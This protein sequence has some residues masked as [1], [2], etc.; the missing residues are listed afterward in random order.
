MKY[1]LMLPLILAA[2][3]LSAASYE[4]DL[5]EAFPQQTLFQKL[6]VEGELLQIEANESDENLEVSLSGPEVEF[7]LTTLQGE[8]W[9]VPLGTFQLHVLSEM[10]SERRHVLFDLEATSLIPTPGK[11]NFSNGSHKLIGSLY[12]ALMSV[13]GSVHVTLEASSDTALDDA[14]IK[15]DLIKGKQQLHLTMHDTANGNHAFW[16]LQSNLFGKGAL[17]DFLITGLREWSERVQEST[18]ESP[19]EEVLQNVC[20]Q[21]SAFMDLAAPLLEW[22]GIVLA[23]DGESLYQNQPDLYELYLKNDFKVSTVTGEWSA[24]MGSRSHYVAG[25]DLPYKWEQEFVVTNLS[26][27]IEK[28]CG[29]IQVNAIDQLAEYLEMPSLK[30]YGSYFPKYFNQA[31]ATLIMK[32]GEPQEDGTLLLAFSGGAVDSSTIGSADLADSGKLLVDAIKE[33]VNGYWGN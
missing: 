20:S 16:N 33:K 31:L 9:S 10:H 27:D 28:L 3:S 17:V 32:L 13:K 2:A 30:Y 6:T 12:K 8:E 19:T 22:D 21:I 11:L 14:M 4:L 15:L 25:V 1:Y 7:R 29:W 5:Q 23:L 18:P 24:F 26:S